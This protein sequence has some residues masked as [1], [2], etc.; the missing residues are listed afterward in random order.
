MSSKQITS[1][2][3]SAL[4][5]VSVGETQSDATGAALGALLKPHLAQG[6]ALPNL[7]LVITLV[8][9]A[10]DAA[11][12]RMVEADAAHEAELGD[13]APLRK[14]RDEAASAL[15]D[16]LV[17]LREVITGVYGAPAASMVF[18]APAPEDPV[19]LSRFAGEVAAQL[20]RVTLP[21]PRLKGAK[22]DIA[23]TVSAL[24]EHS[25]TLDGHLK[26]VARELREAQA[27]L[28][29]KNRAMAAYDERFAGVATTLTGLLRLAGKPELAAKVR[30][31]TRRPGQ[32]AAD[33]EAA[34]EAPAK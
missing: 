14:A 17:E 9:R 5:V 33:A 16:K 32:T 4:A 20:G 19:V 12:A 24:Q 2:E 34:V 30:P 23:E 6:E 26:G 22:L 7:A 21:A 13:D 11:K 3:K 25:A 28:D 15:S 1:R 10:L 27:T 8:A 18:A 31:S 29:V